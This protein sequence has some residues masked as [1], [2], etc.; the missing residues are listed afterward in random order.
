M[1]AIIASTAV[2]LTKYAIIFA[3]VSPG[4]TPTRGKSH[5]GD[6]SSYVTAPKASGN[7]RSGRKDE[8]KI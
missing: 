6:S 8:R 1:I 2:K 3:I 7:I 5:V 4:E